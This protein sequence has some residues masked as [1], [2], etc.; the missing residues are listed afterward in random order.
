M[1]FKSND[2]KEFRKSKGLLID[3]RSPEEYYKGHMPNSINIPIFNNEERSII[4]KK[5]KIAGRESA[6]R[7]AKITEVELVQ[8]PKITKGGFY[9]NHLFVCV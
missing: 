2:L 7:A 9:K 4:G 6:I 8:I 1:N 3:V 5:Y